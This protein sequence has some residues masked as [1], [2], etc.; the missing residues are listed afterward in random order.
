MKVAYRVIGFVGALVFVSSLGWPQALEREMQIGTKTSDPGYVA[1]LKVNVPIKD[2]AAAEQLI[3]DSFQLLMEATKADGW[4]ASGKARVVFE[5]SMENPPGEII[6]FHLQLFIIEEPTKE[7]LEAARDYEL[8]RLE[9]EKVAYTFHKGAVEQLQITLMK[10][11][12]W[13]IGQ[14]LDMEGYPCAIIHDLSSQNAPQV[15]EVQ[16]PT[17]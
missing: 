3:R 4:T 5:V 8:L 12:Q 11:A 13:M 2:R 14:G 6:P 16:I 15:F 10:L 9:A 1:S 17:K 7:E